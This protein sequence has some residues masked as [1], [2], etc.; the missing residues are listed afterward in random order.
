MRLLEPLGFVGIS[1]LMLSPFIAWLLW[2]GFFKELPRQET[3]YKHIAL[4]TFAVPTVLLMLI[5]LVSTAL[6][7]W[8]IH[9]YLL[10]FPLLP[11]AVSSINGR[12]AGG[13]SKVFYA[14]QGIGLLFTTLLS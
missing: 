8:N 13:K 5:S 1:L 7:Y 4:W 2:K 12:V 9:A 10:L 14:A 6:Y 3:V 11:L